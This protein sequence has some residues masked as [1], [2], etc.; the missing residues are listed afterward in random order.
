MRFHFVVLL[1]L[2]AAA[3]YGQSVDSLRQRY[4][5]LVRQR[6]QPL[7]STT[8]HLNQRIDSIQAKLNALAQP[9]L[10]RWFTKKRL[11]KP[12]PDSLEAVHELDSARRGLTHKIDSLKQL[13]LPTGKYAAQIDSLNRIGPSH[14]IEMAKARQ[15]QLE[16]KIN[17]PIAVTN[18]KINQSID[19]V[20][21]NITK[22]LDRVENGLNQ[23]LN[24]I[25]Q[26]GGSGANIP[27]N[28]DLKT[29]SLGNTSLPGAPS[30]NFNVGDNLK[31]GDT[32]NVPNLTNPLGTQTPGLGNI[33]EKVG[34]L[35]KVPQEKINELKSVE[36]LQL[37]KNKVGQVN[38]V[39]DKVQGYGDD[40]KKVAE[41]NIGE[42]K[43]IPDAIEGKVSKLDEIQDL[44]KHQGLGD[45]QQVKDLADKAN[46]PEALREQAQQMVIQEAK[47]HFAGNMEALQAAMDKMSKLKQKYSE[48]S[49]IKDLPKRAP[50]PMKGKPLIERIVPSVT[51]QFQ[52]MPTFDIDFNPMLSYRVTGR[53]LVSGG[54]NERVGFSKWN[55]VVPSERIFGPRA[56]GSFTF[57]KG[58]A[59]KAE[60]EKMNA[61][62]PTSALGGDG[63]RHWLWSAFVGLKRDYN[64]GA[65]IKGNMQVLYNLYDDHDSSPYSER[66]SIRMGFE[67][68]MKKRP[69]PAGM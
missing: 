67:F 40:V 3:S 6:T 28:V 69:K 30:T 63:A 35:T 52:K 31:L 34:D 7:D 14:Y 19:Q 25:R 15:Q 45:M 42:V 39:T 43:S 18:Q 9:D 36:E 48:V 20:G 51:L 13:Q 55:R 65:H 68:P 4:D 16:Q 10:K 24:T 11:R 8:R 37:A 1:T 23:K 54:W 47:D 64:L 46:N 21:D 57:G 41:G 26:E 33:Q 62:I 66:L 29:P 59:V 58:Y 22:P 12:V 56:G 32:P 61:I 60:V 38:Q 5:S 17:Q 53:W 49:S 27:G 44:Q 2:I 50:N